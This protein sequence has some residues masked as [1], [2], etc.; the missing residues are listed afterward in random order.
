MNKFE[1]FYTGPQLFLKP[2]V[3][4][5]TYRLKSYRDYSG[6][7][8]FIRVFVHEIGPDYIVATESTY[9]GGYVGNRIKYNRD[10]KDN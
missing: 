2:R 7:L 5:K 3:V 1:S 8:H 4:G 10:G 9:T 6:K